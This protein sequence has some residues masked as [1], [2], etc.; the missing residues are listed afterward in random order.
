[1]SVKL[2][3]TITAQVGNLA[4]GLIQLPIAISFLTD[5]ELKYW[6]AFLALGGIGQ[7]LEFGML[8]TFTRYFSY[9]SQRDNYNLLE[10]IADDATNKILGVAKYSYYIIA[11]FALLAVTVSGYFYLHIYLGS[12]IEIFYSWLIYG[13]GI[14]LNLY[15][16]RFISLIN[17]INK[18][19]LSN[20]IIIIAK[21]TSILFSW[22]L[23]PEYKLMGFS[24]SSIL[25]AT[26]MMSLAY[27]MH[28]KF[29]GW[30]E[31]KAR[32]DKEIFSKAREMGV[33]QIAAFILQKGVVL[34]AIA[35]YESELAVSFSLTL[36]VFMV[37]STIGTA[38][39]TAK[40]PS[41]NKLM[42]HEK[43]QL[44]RIEINK[45]YLFAVMFYLV[46]CCIIIN[47][48]DAI[49]SLIDKENKLMTGGTLYLIFGM[50][51]LEM[52]HSIAAGFIAASNR[53]P[54]YKA[55]VVTA[56][57][58][59]TGGAYISQKYEMW[60]FIAFVAVAQLSYNNWKWPYYLWKEYDW[61]N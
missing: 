12:K 46:S 25:S 40:M 36:N 52:L 16:N 44:V 5:I 45:S 20:Y 6:F 51:F 28:G 31:I 8:S 39:Q 23:V 22:L 13:L 10:N 26:V 9:N 54:F 53:F 50:V 37:M 17:G 47:F 24:L 58:V 14:C 18:N 41:I 55:G 35:H 4:N 48:G 60:V 19:E 49:F 61:K 43:Y 27:F 15:S 21:S 2:I 33:T 38:Y 57:V 11:S 56:I 59:L 29:T 3:S 30:R 34:M 1:M 7:V 42:N 32:K